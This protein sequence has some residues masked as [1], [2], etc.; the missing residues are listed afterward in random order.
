MNL[1][2]IVKKKSY[3]AKISLQEGLEFSKHDRDGAMFLL[4]EVGDFIFSLVVFD[5][6]KKDIETF[7]YTIRI[8]ILKKISSQNNK[9]WMS[10]H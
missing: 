3:R 4:V 6:I 1:L 7:A 9:I 2:E 10:F 8:G 5:L